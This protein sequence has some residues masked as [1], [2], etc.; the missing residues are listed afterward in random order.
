MSINRDTEGLRSTFA[1]GDFEGFG[2]IGALQ[3]PSPKPLQG[4]SDDYNRLPVQGSKGIHAQIDA[5]LRAARTRPQKTEIQSPQDALKLAEKSALAL[6]NLIKTHTP[7]RNLQVVMET[8]LSATKHLLL[9]LIPQS[10][11]PMGIDAHGSQYQIPYGENGA[12]LYA[13]PCGA[14]GL[15]LTLDL[16]NDFLRSGHQR[17]VIAP[18][19]IVGGSIAE[20]GL[21]LSYRMAVDGSTKDKVVANIAASEESSADPQ[22]VYSLALQACKIARGALQATKIETL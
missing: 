15:F 19:K 12:T 8:V 22:A 2:H 6:F 1:T 9:G 17:I 20:K 18:F 5:A 13:Q 14:D 3:D 16:T 10:L 4:D 7:E 21:H 11:E